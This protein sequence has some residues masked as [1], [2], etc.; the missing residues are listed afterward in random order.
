M[1]EKLTSL[2]NCTCSQQSNDLLALLSDG[3]YQHVTLQTPVLSFSANWRER[4]EG[5]VVRNLRER[6]LFCVN[7]N[8]KEESGGKLIGQVVRLTP[9]ELS[10]VL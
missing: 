10:L 1:N 6:Q 8:D 4:G 9:V 2:L 5:A 7:E 3:R